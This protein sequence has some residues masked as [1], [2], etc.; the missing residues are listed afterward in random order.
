MMTASRLL[1]QRPR[2]TR[3]GLELSQVLE[4]AAEEA[5]AL[6]AAFTVASQVT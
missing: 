1:R 3:D 2:I 5:Q 4:V 6:D